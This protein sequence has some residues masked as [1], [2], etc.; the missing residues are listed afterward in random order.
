MLYDTTTPKPRLDNENLC[1]VIGAKTTLHMAYERRRLC[2]SFE[3]FYATHTC[4]FQ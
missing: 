4:T 2:F 3:Y 1:A